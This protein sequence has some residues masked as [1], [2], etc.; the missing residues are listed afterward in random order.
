MKTPISIRSKIKNALRIDRAFQLVW[1]ASRKWTIL[2]ICLTVIQGIIPL[3]TLYIMK[4][5]VDTIAH[6]VQTG[7]PSGSF[8]RVIY[9]I[10]AATIIAVLQAAIRLISG[11]VSEAQSAIVT[12]YVSST[13]HA[14]SIDLDLAYYENPKYYDTLHRAQREGP[15]RPTKIVNGLTRLLQNGVSLTAMV[16]LLF[17]FHWGVG[18]LL[19]ISTIPGM[20]VQVIHARKRFQWQK[21]RTSAERRAAYL[22]QVLTVDMFAKEIRLFD[23]GSFFSNSYDEIRNLLRGEK[24]TLSRKRSIADFMAQF[25]AAVVL[26]GCLMLITIR[27]LNGV[28]TIGDMVMFFQ[29]FQRGIGHLK[30][31]LTN[32]AALYEDN[33]F[34]AYFFEFLDIQNQI[35]DPA[36]P[37]KLPQKFEKGIKLD[38]VEFGYPGEREAVLKDVSITI[39]AGEVVALVGDNGAGKSTLVK[40]LCRLYEPKQ[41]TITMEDIELHHLTIKDLRRQISI[42]FQDYAK[43]F[44]TVRENIRLGDTSIPLDSVKI[45]EAAGKANADD[46]IR[47]LPKGYDTVLGRWFFSGEELSLGEWQKIVLAR[48]FLRDSKLIILDEPTSSLDVNTE[49]HLYTKF[50]ELIADRSALLISH[51]FSTVRMADRIYVLDDGRIAEEGTHKELMTLKGKYADMYNKQAAWLDNQK[52]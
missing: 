20:F 48:A 10:I 12:D 13:L 31:L 21:K 46:F 40:L 19:F 33:M 9:L 34:V 28:I 2:A 8:K 11:Y 49:Y 36:T 50:R 6:A 18:I 14:K 5:I 41:G 52:G 4:L 37:K 39:G 16:A 35:K 23:L 32:I 42:V 27:A 30:E 38:H 1:K 47:K 26:M 43:Y 51:R 29:A 17:M 15:Y 24:L 22:S 45:Q 7:D 3:F 25:F 44:L